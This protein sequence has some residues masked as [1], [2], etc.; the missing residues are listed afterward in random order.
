[1]SLYKS[2]MTT[3][4]NALFALGLVAVSGAAMAQSTVS[5]TAQSTNANLPDGQ[6]VPMWGYFCGT[7]SGTGVTCTAMNG[8]TQSTTAWQPPLI[9][10]PA[11]A[12]LTITLNNQLSFTGTGVPTSIVIDGQVGGGLGGTPA[13]MASPTHAPYGTTWNGTAGDATPADCTNGTGGGA[14]STF[15]PPAC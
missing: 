6:S 10:V 1:M 14:S 5:L 13:R 7:P 8:S 12:T 15:C 9:R 3:L 4:R 2:K 11:G